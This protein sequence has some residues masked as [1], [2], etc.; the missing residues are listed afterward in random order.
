M[1]T[2]SSK[3]FIGSASFSTPARLVEALQGP[4]LCDVGDGRVGVDAVLG[5]EGAVYVGDR[6]DLAALLAQEL[7][8]EGAGVAEALDRDGRVGELH[9]EV[10]RGTA[11]AEHHALR[12]GRVAA[13]RAAD[14][15]AV[16]P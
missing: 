16:F 15:R 2:G 1:S 12:G 14:L 11:H 6:D 3:S 4:V 5:S 9:A 7:G 10:R 13:S 8:R